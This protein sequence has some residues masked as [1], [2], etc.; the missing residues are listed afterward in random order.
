MHSTSASLP[1]HRVPRKGLPFHQI[2]TEAGLD[3]HTFPRA[4]RC[5]Q[6]EWELVGFHLPIPRVTDTCQYAWRHLVEEYAFGIS[7]YGT[8]SPQQFRPS[9]VEQFDPIAKKKHH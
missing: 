5:H 8:S 9:V 4:R 1:L 3:G 7:L 6:M 2:Q